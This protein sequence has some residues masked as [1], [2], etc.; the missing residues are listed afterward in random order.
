M[1]TIQ[2]MELPIPSN[3]QDFEIL[4]RDAQAQRWK[5]TTLQ[6][7]GRPGQRQNGV[8]IYGPDEIGRP[9]G[10]QCKRYK[11]PLKLKDVTDEI[12]KAETFKGRLTALFVATTAD[13][14][15]KL[16][17]QV[18]LLSDK[19]V[20]VGK[21]AVA[22]IYWEDVIG[23]LLLNPAVFQAHYPQVV[24]DQP[25]TVNKERL[26]AALELGYHGADLWASILLIHGEFGWMAQ[27]DPDE[28]I[29]TLRVL[30][31]RAV[32]LLSPDDASPILESLTAVR[33][34]CLAPKTGES[35]WDPIEVQ[36]K[37][38]SSRLQK[39]SSLLPLAE[40]NVLDLGLQLGRMY[41]HADNLPAVKVRNDVKAKVEA[42][43]PGARASAI[44]SRFASAKTLTSGYR[45]AMRIFTLLDHEIRYRL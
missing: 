30:E 9:V 29:A 4:V 17:E 6:K 31:R 42:V 14:D 12:T 40:S 41:H 34:G 35:D 37:R 38:V 5:S 22:L 16:Q 43:L 15:A 23:G 10:I 44:K 25:T 39:A 8:D 19:R 7:N 11:P 36:A 20:A 21:F 28:L 27:A 18:R 13:H 1:P 26:I 24:L 33:E 45:W 32:Q 3:W 2:S